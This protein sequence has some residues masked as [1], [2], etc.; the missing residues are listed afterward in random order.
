[1]PSGSIREIQ[2]SGATVTF[3]IGTSI[4]AFLAPASVLPNDRD[5]SRFGTPFSKAASR[6]R[7]ILSLCCIEKYGLSEIK[8]LA[9]ELGHLQEGES[10]YQRAAHT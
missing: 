8:D 4:A 2:N 10:W 7:S 1:V 5:Q 9:S 3:T 6:Q